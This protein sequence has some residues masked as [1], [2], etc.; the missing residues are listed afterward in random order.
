M[1]NETIKKNYFFGYISWF[2]HNCLPVSDHEHEK[3]WVEKN[4]HDTCKMKIQIFF[5]RIEKCAES[6]YKL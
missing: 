6:L 2:P 4:E 5:Y 3:E 1:H